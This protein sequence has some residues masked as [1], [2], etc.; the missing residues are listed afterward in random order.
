MCGNRLKCWNTMPVVARNRAS[1]L[2]SGSFVP[3]PNEKRVSPT[4]TLPPSG[5]TRRLTQRSSVDLPEP[6]GPI[7]A[8][9]PPLATSRLMPFKTSLLPKLLRRPRISIFDV[10]LIR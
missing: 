4:R 1:V 2:T 8:T 10:S 7:S 9:T 6:D 5:V 3:A